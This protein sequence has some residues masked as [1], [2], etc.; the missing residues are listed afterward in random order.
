MREFNECPNKMGSAHLELQDSIWSA[1]RRPWSRS[2]DEPA[3]HTASDSSCSPLPFAAFFAASVKTS[4][5]MAT[6][7]MTIV[8]VMWIWVAPSQAVVEEPRWELNPEPTTV[9]VYLW[10]DERSVFLAICKSRA[11]IVADLRDETFGA[12][13]FPLHTEE[14]PPAIA[15]LS[16][17]AA[18]PF[19]PPT[20]IYTHHVTS[21]HIV[22]SLS[23]VLW[24]SLQASISVW[25]CVVTTPVCCSHAVRWRVKFY[26]ELT[27]MKSA[28]AMATAQVMWIWL[29][30]SQAVV[31]EPR[32][33]SSPEPTMAIVDGVT[34]WPIKVWHA[35]RRFVF[36]KHATSRAIH[37][38][39]SNL[40][41]N[42][43]LQFW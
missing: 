22:A 6:A 27:R 20:L 30:P 5:E 35:E 32:L 4:N 37:L 17:S 42:C 36:S 40:H 7:T 19:R 21:L 29:V 43:G 15:A 26:G 41:N 39:Q 38:I 1:S 33:E 31:E 23:Q 10:Y 34:S 9:M 25:T 3:C 12:I 24:A 14:Q 8:M 11:L 13:L 16:T 2:H 18:C 28:I